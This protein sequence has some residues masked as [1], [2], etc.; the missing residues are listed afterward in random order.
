MLH[1]LAMCECRYINDD[2]KG[3]TSNPSN[4]RIDAA[5]N[6]GTTY[7][8]I[9]MGYEQSHGPFVFNLY[10]YEAG[11]DQASSKDEQQQVQA[12]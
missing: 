3:C 9:V 11:G 4:S 12:S 1:G 5:L 6:A 7:F 2:D 8:F 10:K